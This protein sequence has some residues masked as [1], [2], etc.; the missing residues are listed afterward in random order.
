MLKMNKMNK[1]AQF[2]TFI[3]VVVFIFIVGILL[4]FLNHFNKTFYDKFDEY[5]EGSEEYN[6]TEAHNATGKLQAIEDSNI[7]DYAFLAIFFGFVL[8]I[9][10]LSFASKIN[11]AFFWILVI[12]DIPILIIGTI[13]SNVW[14]GIVTNPEF[15]TTITRFPITNAI[16]GTY[17][18]MVVTIILFLAMI[19]L[20]GKPS[21]GEE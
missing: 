7:W 12:V 8:Q 6:N 2:T 20:F 4:F 10:L 15:A 9:I 5:F 18:P 3:M 14:Q 17:Y 21:R 13:V 1:K 16:L 19:I 11:A